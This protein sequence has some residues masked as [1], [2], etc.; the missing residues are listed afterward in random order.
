MRQEHIKY[1][2]ILKSGG[3]VF[4]CIVWLWI[5]VG[6]SDNNEQT[7][8]NGTNLGNITTQT[9]ILSKGDKDCPDGGIRIDFFEDGI[10]QPEQTQVVC[11]D[12]GT[13]VQMT[14]LEKGNE[15]CPYGGVQIDTLK[16]GVVQNDQTQY[17]CNAAADNTGDAGNQNDQGGDG[18]ACAKNITPKIIV[19][20]KVLL[21]HERD[22]A[23]PLTIFANKA[24]LD[25]RFIAP[26][27]V[28]VADGEEIE[29]EG[30]FVTNYTVK[31]DG[32]TRAV[33]IAS[34]GCEVTL[35]EFDIASVAVDEIAGIKIP[36]GSFSHGTLPLSDYPVNINS[37]VMA[38]TETTV[39]QFISC[40]A[41]GACTVDNYQEY[42]GGGSYCNYERGMTWLDHPMNCINLFGAQEYC[43]WIGGRLPTAD[44]WQ[45]A[46]THNGTISQETTYPWGNDDPSVC[47]HANYNYMTS[48]TDFACNGSTVIDWKERSGTAM[49]G[50]YPRGNSPLGLNDM[51]GNVAEWTQSLWNDEYAVQGASWSHGTWALPVSYFGQYSAATK[52]DSIGFRCVIELTD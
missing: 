17:V 46:S 22:K 12:S 27:A 1:P 47:I 4:L 15:N 50:T 51:S 36:S 20:F 33:I 25:Y 19:E 34:D 39:R 14:S 49:V 6:C 52:D 48:S 9:T 7:T 23:Y 45:Y 21:T 42:T 18:N 43:A 28:I 44:E 40:I 16:D 8:I 5:F 26:G 10:I 35:A 37:F 3:G 24:G 29:S 2:T 41:A 13:T 30:K 11:G 31:S 38:K 32:A